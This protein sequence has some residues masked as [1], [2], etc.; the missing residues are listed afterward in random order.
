MTSDYK[1]NSRSAATL[2]FIAGVLYAAL[3]LLQFLSSLGLFVHWTIPGDFI[4]GLILIILSSVFFTGVRHFRRN[5][6]DAFAFLIVG[7]ILAGVVFFLH[8]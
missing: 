2:S 5:A 6:K 3:G 8:L 1:F 4:V 7:M